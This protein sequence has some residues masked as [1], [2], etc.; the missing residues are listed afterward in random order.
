MDLF[1]IFEKLFLCVAIFIFSRI[2]CCT[3]EDGFDSLHDKSSLD[4]GSA[5]S[6]SFFQSYNCQLGGFPHPHTHTHAHNFTLKL[7]KGVKKS[8]Q[9]AATIGHQTMTAFPTFLLQLNQ[10]LHCSRHNKT[11]SQ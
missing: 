10:N 2:F 3:N 9:G 6:S 8:P 4:L 1:C 11:F 5:V 7:P